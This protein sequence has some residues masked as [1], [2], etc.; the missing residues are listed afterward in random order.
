MLQQWKLAN[1]SCDRNIDQQD[2]K[3]KRYVVVVLKSGEPI[4]FFFYIKEAYMVD[5]TQFPMLKL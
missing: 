5:K 4:R 2:P 1:L 3:S